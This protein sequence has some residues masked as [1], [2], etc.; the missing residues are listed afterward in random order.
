M[1]HQP[2]YLYIVTIKSVKFLL[3]GGLDLSALK[4]YYP[5]FCER[6]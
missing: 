5:L 4:H 2:S 3:T 1:K 6:N